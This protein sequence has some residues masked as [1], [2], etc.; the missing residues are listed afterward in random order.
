MRKA[1]TFSNLSLMRYVRI[2]FKMKIISQHL[3]EWN[4]FFFNFFF[5]LNNE[6]LCLSFKIAFT[7]SNGQ[8][9]WNE[10]TTKSTSFCIALQIYFSS[11]PC[12]FQL[13]IYFLWNSFQ[14]DFFLL[15]DETRWRNSD[16]EIQKGYAS[17]SKATNEISEIKKLRLAK[18]R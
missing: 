9:E 3:K 5:V 14:S 12:S 10:T 13:K 1:T 7:R 18:K 8:L 6:D 2:F 17:Y 4:S 11:H 15:W 16:V